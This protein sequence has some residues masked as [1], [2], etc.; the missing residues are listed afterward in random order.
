MSALPR[1]VFDTA[2][3]PLRDRYAAWRESISIYEGTP[4]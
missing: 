1:S 2:S 3:L 4:K